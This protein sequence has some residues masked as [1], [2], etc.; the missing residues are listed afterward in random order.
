MII[1]GG[2]FS[3]LRIATGNAKSEFPGSKVEQV[4]GK[5]KRL[6][7]H[8]RKEKRKGTVPFRSSP[9]RRKKD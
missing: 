4:L 2:Y 9:H 6:E 1:A 8:R 7:K 3:H 5:G